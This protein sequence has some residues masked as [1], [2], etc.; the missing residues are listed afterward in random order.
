MSIKSLL[1]LLFPSF[2]RFRRERHCCAA[3][4]YNN[5]LPAH[6]TA[7]YIG[8]RQP[9]ALYAC[10]FPPALRDQTRRWYRNAAGQP[11]RNVNG[12]F[13]LHKG[14]EAAV[15]LVLHNRIQK[16]QIFIKK[17]SFFSF[18]A[19]ILFIHQKCKGSHQKTK[20]V[21][22]NQIAFYL[23]FTLGQ[24]N[25]ILIVFICIPPNFI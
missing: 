22:N 4:G 1:F 25:I 20:A 9:K 21:C 23:Q 19:F 17:S 11:M 5:T 7:L 3:A 2:F 13:A 12:R 10:R 24:V 15:N 16:P 8:R 6:S 14:I 18:R